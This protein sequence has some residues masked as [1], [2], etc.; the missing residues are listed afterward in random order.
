VED[1]QALSNVRVLEL[2]TLIAGPYASALLGQ[3]GAE[4]VKIE[5]PDGDPLRG[6]RKLHAGTSLWWHAQSRNKRSV[7]IDLRTTAGQEIVRTLARSADVVV[8]NFRPGTL[9]KWGLGWDD[10]HALHPKLVMVRVS[11]YGQTGPARDRP[12]FAAIAEAMG[13]LRYI[14]GYPDRPP[15]RTGVSLGDT[16]AGLYG[17]LGALVAIHHVRAGGPGQLVDVALYEAVLAV[18]E[19]MI[20]EYGLFSFVRE[21]SGASLPGI[22]PSNTYAC[23]DGAYVIIAGNG[24]AIFR[25]LARAMGRPD[26]ADDPD[27]A[28][29]EGRVRQ[30]A[31]LDEAISAW[32]RARSEADVLAALEA[33]EVP[34]GAIYS[35]ADVHRDPHIRAREM[36]ERHALRDGTP[37]DLPGVVPRLSETPGRTRW[38]GPEL[39]EHTAEVLASIGIAGEDLT[40]LRAA[41]V[42][43]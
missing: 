41:G 26:L 36:I 4:I 21:R 40:A 2:G 7:A 24:D 30:V 27:L 19:S 37:V 17:A 13:G 42:V 43:R 34:A 20:P 23:A 16:L 12:G 11:G 5:P 15:V 31:R 1:S 6:W 10:L 14:T 9:E 22:A 39:G 38:L 8:E 29:N 18:T 35:A 3:F 32:T 28:H 33:A 25:R